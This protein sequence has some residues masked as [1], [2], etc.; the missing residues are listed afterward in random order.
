[1]LMRINDLFFR[2]IDDVI[3]EEIEMM[4]NLLLDTNKCDDESE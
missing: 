3:P 1:M 4:G 2:K